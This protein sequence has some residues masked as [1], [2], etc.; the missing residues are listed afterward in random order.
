MINCFAEWLTGGKALG[1]IS[2]WDQ[3][4]DFSSLQKTDTLE[5]GFGPTQN[6]SSIFFE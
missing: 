5:A 4:Q 3:S 1:I 6:P 2:R